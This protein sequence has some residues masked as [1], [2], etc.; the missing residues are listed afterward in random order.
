[1]GIKM[2]MDP[3]NQGGRYEENASH[4]TAY[5]SGKLED[6]HADVKELKGDVNN[7]KHD[8][9]KMNTYFKLAAVVTWL[10][11]GV[12]LSMSEHI[13]AGVHVLGN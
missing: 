9:I 4:I 8:N 3:R 5:L 13:I 10:A 7:L 2:N 11:I 1:M 6:I 12:L